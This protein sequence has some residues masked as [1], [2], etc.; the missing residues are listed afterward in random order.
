MSR[1]PRGQS[2]TTIST[3]LTHDMQQMR[4]EA[5]TG[6]DAL[7][8]L[9]EQKLEQ[10]I[11]QQADSAKVL[12]DELGGNFDRLGIRVAASLAETG[13]IQLE[14]LENVTNAL[15]VFSEK[16]EKAQENLRLTVETS[17][18]NTRSS[19]PAEK[20]AMRRCGCLSMQSFQ[21][22]ITK[23][24]STPRSVAT[25]MQ[26]KHHPKQSRCVFVPLLKIFVTNTFIRHIALILPCYFCRP[27]ACLPRL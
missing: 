19:C 4:G 26:S 8:G 15:S 7:R 18:S 14:R 27:R 5:N 13:Q 24:W 12:R 17:A 22:R 21:M 2:V 23:N 6:R 10:N 1:R 11:S 25:E 20:M 16:S 9:I 3:K